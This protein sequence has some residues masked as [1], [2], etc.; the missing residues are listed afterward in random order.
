MV[1]SMPVDAGAP[2]PRLAT[3]DFL[4]TDRDQTLAQALVRFTLA[5]E[6]VA[7]V[8]PPFG[9]LDRLAELAL[10]S[11]LPDLT[12]DDLDRIAE[13]HEAGFGRG[14]RGGRRDVEEEA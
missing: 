13:R 2:D 8:L 7:A 5:L 10:A 14:D 12:P 4:T 6:P 1:A 9:D 11:D 3:L